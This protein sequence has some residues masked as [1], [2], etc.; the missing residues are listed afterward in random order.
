MEGTVKHM[1]IID[2][3]THLM[4]EMYANDIEEVINRCKEHDLE[5][6]INI[7][8]DVPSSEKAVELAQKYDW[9]YAIVGLHP[10]ACNEPN[11]DLKFI[12]KLTKKPKVVAIGEIGLD[13][14]YEETNRDNQKAG[15]I[16]QI[17]LANKLSLP[18]CIHSRD[19]DMD[20]IQILKEHKINTGFVMHCFSSSVEI[21]KE[22]LKL[23]GFISLAGTVTFKNARNLL[24]VAKMVP[25]DK[26]LLETDAP[27]LTPEPYRGTRNEP[28]H[29]WETANKVAKLR[30]ISLD[31]LVEQI[32]NNCR[33]IYKI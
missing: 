3:H 19:A 20:M 29:V 30:E 7:G 23:G 14:H 4:D 21:A 17:E 28:W 16:K 25:I 12:K 13:Y 8:Y 1:K 33:N 5:A 9:M 10:D 18:V 6:V 2:S 32:D 26:L 27:Y 11:V 31:E 24:E 22:I 15:F